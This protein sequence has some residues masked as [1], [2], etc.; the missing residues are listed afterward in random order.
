MKE[1]MKEKGITLVALV[2]T[3]I[4]LLILAGVTLNLALADNGLFSKAKDAVEKYKK[5]E[6]DEENALSKMTDMLENITINYNDYVGCYVDGYKLDIK[7]CII[8][9]DETGVHDNI[10]KNNV[11]ADN[12]TADG[13]QTF[14]TENNMKW[15]IW[16][17]DENKKIIRL[18]SEK[19]TN[20]TLT[21][22]GATGYNNGIYLLNK[23][24]KE[25][26]T[27]SGIKGIDVSSIK[28][29]DIEKV[30]TYD[31]TQYKHLEN[32]WEEDENGTIKYGDTTTSS[33]NNYY[34]LMWGDNDKNWTYKNDNG[35]I[36]GDKEGLIF[37]K[38]NE[39]EY[40]SDVK[41]QAGDSSTQFR[42][43]YYSHW[44]ERSE[45][46]NPKYYDLLFN[47]KFDCFYWLAT[48]AVR[49]EHVIG[50]GLQHVN[51]E[52]AEDQMNHLLSGWA[53]YNSSNANGKAYHQIRPIVSINLNSSNCNITKEEKD[54]KVTFKLNWK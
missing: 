18:I 1:Q 5:A 27:M 17:Y 9:P 25:C 8:T 15:Q 51:S 40:I 38:G 23:I 14:T 26:Y 6:E 4:I 37:E 46:K 3:I 48:R 54:G 36:T 43:S 39:K 13:T 28:R 49:I 31:Y 53:I 29:S 7:T 44:Y 41:S 2:V 32:S 24:C 42:Q 33:N 11:I 30:S 45:F 47:T 35:E 22:H 20:D 19:P 34:P 21:L 50:Y 12:I 52:S 10:D 16:D